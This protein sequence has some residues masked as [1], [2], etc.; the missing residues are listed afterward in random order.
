MLVRKHARPQQ[1][2]PTVM[3]EQRPQLPRVYSNL[4]LDLKQ[5]SKLLVLLMVRK[6][7]AL[8]TRIAFTGLLN[9]SKE[10]NGSRLGTYQ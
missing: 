7:H 3:T 6:P 4:N 1:F 9:A 5:S 10:S 8:L 2:G